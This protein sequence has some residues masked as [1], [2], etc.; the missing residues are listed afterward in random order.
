[1][2][3]AILAIAALGGLWMIGATPA[4]AKDYAYCLQT[5]SFGP[6][7]CEYDTYAQC[8]ATAQGLN[9]DCNINPRVAFAQQ[10]G[11]YVDGPVRHRR[12]RHSH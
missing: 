3:K 1:M 5:D 6:G 7:R 12:H 11:V 4:A 10:R 2:K 9:A 8:R